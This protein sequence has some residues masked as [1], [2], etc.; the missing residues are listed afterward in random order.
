MN[1]QDTQR[2]ARRPE[3]RPAASRPRPAASGS[4]RRGTATAT[5]RR[6]STAG[7]RTSRPPKVEKEIVYTPVKPFNRKRLLL[8]LGI[9]A[10]VVVAVIFTLSLF[11][12][13][14]TVTVSGNERYSIEAII[15]ASGIENGD[16][17]LSVND[18]KVSGKIITELP[19]VK[20][21]RIGI[22]LPGAVNIEIEELDV[23]YSVADENGGWWKM[24]SDGRIVEKTDA[25]G[26]TE[27]TKILGVVLSGPTAGQQATAQEATPATDAEGETQPVTITGAQR[28]Q[29]ALSILQYLEKNGVLGDMVSVDVSDMGNIELWYGQRFRILLGDTT[30]LSY[31]VSMAVAAVGQLRD[32]ERG[33]LDVTFLDRPEV[34]YTPGT[35]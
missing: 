14:D 32:Y 9:V 12:K 1:T 23:V 15:K 20:S 16:N 28:L 19:Y 5:A 6:P 25:A 27:C 29:T 26:A 7:P 2:Q 18:A 3:G 4:R 30:E 35:D 11:F 21:V 31:K 13:V 17:L 8:Q 24:T 10:A 34:V 33:T 22:K